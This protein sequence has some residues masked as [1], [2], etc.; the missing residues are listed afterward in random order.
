MVC[1]C[2][3]PSNSVWLQIIFCSCVKETVLFSFLRSLLRENGRSPRFPRIFIK[4]N[5]LSDRMIKQL[6]NSVI[7]KYHDLSVSRRSI[8][9]LSLRLQQII[10]LLATDK[11]RYFAQPR[12]IILLNDW[13]VVFTQIL[14]FIPMM[15][16]NK[17]L[18]TKQLH[19]A[20][21][22][23]LFLLLYHLQSFY[24]LS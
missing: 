6:L 19:T 7:A 15:S 14:E 9:C 13:S 17:D 4:K 1:S 8:I 10:D 16:G 5:K 22:C 2:A 18:C 23:R 3:M 12:P 21:T 11:S 24:H 20:C